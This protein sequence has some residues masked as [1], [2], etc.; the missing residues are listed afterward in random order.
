MGGIL[1]SPGQDPFSSFG[2]GYE[3]SIANLLAMER[4]Q[5]QKDEDDGERSADGADI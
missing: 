3:T 2:R 5:R 1:F 4:E